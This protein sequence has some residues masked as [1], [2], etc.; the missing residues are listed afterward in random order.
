MRRG[1]VPSTSSKFIFNRH[2]SHDH[3]SATAQQSAFVPAYRPSALD[4][5][6][7]F[8][9]DVAPAYRNLRHPPPPV[10]P[11]LV[12]R[13][14]RR[15]AVMRRRGSRAIMRRANAGSVSKVGV[16]KARRYPLGRRNPAKSSLHTRSACR[17]YKLPDFRAREA[18]KR[19]LA[20]AQIERLSCVI[21][22]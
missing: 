17:S 4:V 6:T 12:S 21:G 10:P 9:L 20:G 14:S 2:G 7:S 1:D 15:A 13:M 5:R 22:P 11:P 19:H 18:G 3:V 16:S 8:S